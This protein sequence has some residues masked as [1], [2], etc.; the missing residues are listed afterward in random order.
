MQ[1]VYY[2]RILVFTLYVVCVHRH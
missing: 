1:M 2:M